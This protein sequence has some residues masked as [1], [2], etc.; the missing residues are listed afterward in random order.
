LGLEAIQSPCKGNQKPISR[1]DIEYTGRERTED[2]WKF[3][4]AL[5]FLEQGSKII[6]VPHL[7]CPQT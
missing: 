6:A 5:D 7:K 3:M 1:K 2:S 4:I